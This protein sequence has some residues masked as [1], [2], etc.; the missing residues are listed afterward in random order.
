MLLGSQLRRLR[1]ARGIT[2]DAAGY[3]IRASE[4]RISRMEMG[5]VSFKTRD[6]EDLLTL[7]GITDNAA[8]GALVDLAR[9]ANLA[10]WWHR[11][12]DVLPNWFATYVGLES[13]ASLIRTFEVQLVPGLLQT[14]AYA[15]AVISRSM[16]DVSAADIDRHVALRM[17]RQKILLS[18]NAPSLHIVL[19]EAV[20]HRTDGGRDVMRGQLRHLIE[21]SENPDVLL[22][23]MP[24][25]FGGHA[26][27]S[28]A[29]TILGFLEY[30]LTDVVYV[31][32][33][34]SALYLDRREDVAQYG[35]ALKE[36]QQESLGPDGSRDLLREL[37]RLP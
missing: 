34:T 11:Y 19:D 28:G 15:R 4:S 9:D 14:E 5:R 21:L 1:E 23:I 22:Q 31:E 16:R 18:E 6:V 27:E 17:E 33:L 24:F 20:L 3:V 37:I 2:R 36:L 25:S 12:S 10:G 29:F 7:Y 26:G 13:A 35:R 8:R 30:D 32:Q